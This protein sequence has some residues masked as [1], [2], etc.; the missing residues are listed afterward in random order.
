M[1]RLCL[2]AVFAIAF[3][4]AVSTQQPPVFRAGTDTVRVFVT[5]TD[6]SERLLTDLA[7]D[8]F[9]I[10]DNGRPQP[11]TLFDSTPQPIRLVVM[12]DVSTSMMG[13]LPL[14]RTAC[15]E[16][17]GHLRD[18]DLARVGTFGQ[19]ITIDPTFTRDPASLRSSLPTEISPNAPTPLWRAM[20]EAINTLAELEERRVVLVLSD[21][22]DS[23][24]RKFGEKYI[25]QLEVVER[26]QR[27][28]VMLYGIGMRSRMP[29]FPG[30]GD[31][32]TMLTADLPDP[33]LG[34]VALETG[35]GYVEI[36]AHDNLA[37]AFAH[38]ADELH[39]QYLLGFTPPARDGKVHKIEVKIGR[40]DAK[41][42]A[43]KNYVAPKG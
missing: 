19:E 17:F 9:Q 18:D 14:L 1:S 31:I 7:R 6:K 11:L 21:G 43:R 4:Q 29:G 34:T 32:R 26:A 35:G 30:G 20:N 23:G 37:A 24:P 12:L 15:V 40:K 27:D 28:E 3:A 22:K 38:V 5:V 42:R 16:L 41:P 2:L 25:T 33:G 10:L 13:N 8:D 36:K 39:S